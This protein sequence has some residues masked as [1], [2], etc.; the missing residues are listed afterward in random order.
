MNDAKIGIMVMPSTSLIIQIKT[1]KV[2]FLST[3]FHTK[4]DLLKCSTANFLV[5]YDF[6]RMRVQQG[7]NGVM[8]PHDWRL[9][10]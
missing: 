1:A 6:Y 4:D 8:R 2:K 10:M 5:D 9:H 7:R 3:V